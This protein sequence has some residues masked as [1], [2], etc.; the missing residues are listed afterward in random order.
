M[1]IKNIFFDFDGVLAESV[2]AKTIAFKE[3]YLSYGKDIAN[4]V[5]EYHIENGGV[6]RYEKFRYWEKQFFGKDLSKTE[7]KQMADR[8]SELVLQKVIDSEAVSESLWFLKKY[9]KTL[10]FWV[11][12]G[13]PTAEIEKIAKA[14]KIDCF[15]EGLH[16]SPE[17]KI[18]WSEYLL[19]TYNLDRT[20][21][22]FLGDAT[23]DM[24]AAKF[25]KLHFALRRNKE[26]RELFKDYDGLEFE[27]FKQLE[28][29]LIEQKLL[30]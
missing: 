11:I 4:K 5:V 16:G 15:F 6:S 30:Y 1:A 24:D 2:S 23:T 13:T 26:N 14:R 7:L 19:R 27:D 25:S 12:T 20:E 8:F 17:N 28:K 10:R 3:M 9:N 21:T 29:L 18:H 22:L